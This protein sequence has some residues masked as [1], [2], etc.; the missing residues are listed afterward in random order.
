MS[1]RT[2]AGRP[3]SVRC[4]HGHS[5]SRRVA[6]LA[7][8]GPGRASIRTGSDEAPCA[9]PMRRTSSA[10]PPRR[11]TVC[12]PRSR[13]GT[14]PARPPPRRSST[15]RGLGRRGRR[16]ARPRGLLRLPGQPAPGRARRDGRR[17]ITW[18]TTRRRWSPRTPAQRPRRRPGA[19]HRAVVPVARPSHRADGVRPAGSAS[20]TVVTLGA[21]LADVA[22]HAA[23]PGDRDV[24]RRGRPAPLDLELEHATRARPASSACSRT[25]RPQAGLPSISLLGGRPALRGHPPVAQGHARAARRLEELLDE[26]DPARRARRRLARR[27]SAAST[28]WPRPTPRSPSTSQSLEEAKDT[29]DLP[30]ASGD[31]I[32]QEFERYLRRRRRPTSRSAAR[33]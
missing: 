25:P 12:S 33:G 30:E 4:G 1:Q 16:R 6:V 18:R 13:A 2:A 10:R 26:P 9:G 7:R 3:R 5:T 29:A 11:E 31:A 8:H 24:R 20:T 17:R 28:S 21:L 23:D 14:T 22:A 27:G 32:A 15:C 19:G